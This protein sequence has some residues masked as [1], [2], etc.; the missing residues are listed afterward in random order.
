MNFARNLKKH[1]KVA[2]FAKKKQIQKIRI[3]KLRESIVENWRKEKSQTEETEKLLKQLN[4]YGG[5]WEETEVVE[6]VA[7]F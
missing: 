4:E 5:V 1:Q 3:A 6:K 2:H 7:A